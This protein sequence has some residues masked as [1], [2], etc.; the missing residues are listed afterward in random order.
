MTSNSKLR[1]TTRRVYVVLVNENKPLGSRELMG[2]AKLG[3]PSEVYRQLQKLEDLGL[4]KKD[5][6]GGCMV[7]QKHHIRGYFW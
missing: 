1:G 5:R 6:S 4:V 2:F 3:S 7:K